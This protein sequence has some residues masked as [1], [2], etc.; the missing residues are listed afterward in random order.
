M[1]LTWSRW[2]PPDA[3]LVAPG[4]VATVIGWGDRDRRD[5]RTN[6]PVNLYEVD[7]PIR[8]NPQCTN[9]YGSGY[10]AAKMLCAG[11]LANGGR[12]SCQGDSGG[13]LLVPDGGSGWYQAGIVSWGIGCGIARFPG[14]YTR[15]TRYAGFLSPYLPL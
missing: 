2:P 5:G 10:L 15:L 7:V 6:F 11:D 14:V 1:P 4:T 12:D 9:A 3:S 8:T 13:P